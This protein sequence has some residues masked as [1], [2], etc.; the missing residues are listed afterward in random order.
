MAIPYFPKKNFIS[1]RE[2]ELNKV[3]VRYDAVIFSRKAASKLRH[4]RATA[5]FLSFFRRKKDKSEW[6][7]YLFPPPLPDYLL[8]FSEQF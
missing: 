5:S 8:F 2:K 1:F 6:V 3:P 7:G 4:S